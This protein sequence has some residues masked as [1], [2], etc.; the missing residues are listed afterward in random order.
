VSQLIRGVMACVRS[1][2]KG[3]AAAGRRV[4]NVVM[5]TDVCGGLKSGAWLA[6]ASRC[7]EQ[8]WAR[9]VWMAFETNHEGE[10]ARLVDRNF[11]PLHED[12]V[13]II[14]DCMHSGDQMQSLL[15]ELCRGDRNVPEANVTIVVPYATRKAV[16]KI[17]CNFPHVGMTV[18]EEVPHGV[19]NG[20]MVMFQHTQPDRR[21]LPRRYFGRAG[22]EG[23][24]EEANGWC[25]WPRG[26]LPGLP[27]LRSNPYEYC[28]H[29]P[30]APVSSATWGTS[31]YRAIQ[32]H[33]D[34]T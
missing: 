9:P 1:A 17:L 11:A 26:I 6:A 12:P 18:G 20:S 19:G 21:S 2:R 7:L 8:P 24:K 33:R 15:T 3:H 14:D 27:G 4:T 30:P 22:H 13:M 5:L 25:G 10:R 29:P 28:I 34:I 31:L 32:R 23:G 16:D